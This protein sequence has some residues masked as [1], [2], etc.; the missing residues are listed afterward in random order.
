[1]SLYPL[2]HMDRLV[3]SGKTH[4][5]LD[6]FASLPADLANYIFRHSAAIWHDRVFDDSSRWAL[7]EVLRTT[8]Q[9]VRQVVFI[10]AQWDHTLTQYD[11]SAIQNEAWPNI[12]SHRIQGSHEPQF[13]GV[14]QPAVGNSITLSFLMPEVSLT[15]DVRSDIRVLTPK[16]RWALELYRELSK[17]LLNIWQS[18]EEGIALGFVGSL[19]SLIT[20]FSERFW[21]YE[22]EKSMLEK[23]HDIASYY[24]GIAVEH[25]REIQERTKEVILLGAGGM[26]GRRVSEQLRGLWYTII[27]IDEGNQGS[28]SRRVGKTP[29]LVLD[30]TL[31]S[32]DHYWPLLPRGSIFINE[33]YSSLSHELLQDLKKNGIWVY[34]IA[35]VPWTSYPPLLGG[36][37]E[38]VPCCMVYDR[39][40]WKTLVK[41][42]N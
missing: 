14:I 6:Q 2:E 30:C 21:L 1:M 20:K 3:T 4:L 37:S 15:G 31:G 24:V 33:S 17:N 10:V 7:L 18:H 36:Y 25:V 13:F 34:H 32:L 26:L 29:R 11:A 28:F 41:R 12:S 39:D 22:N 5:F 8:Q 42:V 9:Y 23:K 27:G 19:P 16:V 40:Q 35:W 38:W